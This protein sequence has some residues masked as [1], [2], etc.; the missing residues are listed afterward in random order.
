MSPRRSASMKDLLI[1]LEAVQRAQATLTAHIERGDRDA[2]KTV[3][4]LVTI[5]NNRDVVSAMDA[6]YPK[7]ASPS[8]AP[9]ESPEVQ[10]A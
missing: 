7:V 3:N 5:L 4:E 1:I 6:V 2:E 9:G 8:V 10:K